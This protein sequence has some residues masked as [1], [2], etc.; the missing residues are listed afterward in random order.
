MTL[1]RAILSQGAISL[2]GGFGFWLPG[3]GVKGGISE[4]D[5]HIFVNI[6]SGF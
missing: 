5:G 3:W 6:Y 2:S 4:V 1:A